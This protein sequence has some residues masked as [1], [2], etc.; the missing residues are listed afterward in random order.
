MGIIYSEPLK[1]GRAMGIATV[2]E[3]TDIIFDGGSE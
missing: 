3:V 2:V 1:S